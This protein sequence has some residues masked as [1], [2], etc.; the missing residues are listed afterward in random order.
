M[1]KRPFESGADYEPMTQI[2]DIA[3]PLELPTGRQV[4]SL[5]EL[6]RR[7]GGSGAGLLHVV[8][9]EGC[10]APLIAE[11]VH[12]RTQRHVVLVTENTETA[13]RTADDLA[14]VSAPR[15]T[16]D[17]TVLY[18]ASETSPYAEVHPERSAAMDRTAAL[19]RLARHTPWNFL[20]VTAASLVRRVPPAAVLLGVG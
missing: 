3:T 8:G 12:L 6:V 17:G 13:R 14:F 5:E 7:I 11:A 10:A 1:R 9:A 20:V 15:A 4:L 18:A 19:H 16:P 2:D